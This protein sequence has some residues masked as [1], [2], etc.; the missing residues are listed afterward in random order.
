[1][2][3]YLV[4][5]AEVYFTDEGWERASLALEIIKTHIQNNQKQFKDRCVGKTPELDKLIAHLPELNIYIT[6]TY[7]GNNH[8][9][10]DVDSILNDIIMENQIEE[11]TADF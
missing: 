1:M 6:S 7:P 3:L 9:F 10:Y 2:R 5:R 8:D 4:N 11:I